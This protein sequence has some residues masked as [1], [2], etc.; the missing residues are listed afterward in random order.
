MLLNL[1]EFYKT[2]F[3]GCVMHKEHA[4]KL[5]GYVNQEFWSTC[6]KESFLIPEWMEQGLNLNI[7]A[8]ISGFEKEAKTQQNIKKYTPKHY[9]DFFQTIFK[10]HLY[11]AGINKMHNAQLIINNVELWNGVS[12][13][14]CH[15]HWDGP[16]NGD[17][18]A[19]VYLSDYKVWRV[20]FGG[21]LEV[22][23]AKAVAEQDGYNGVNSV[24]VYHPDNGRILLGDNR[25]PLYVHRANPL[26]EQA[27]K[28]INRFTFLVSMK[29]APLEHEE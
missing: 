29:L 21:G 13:G 24:A 1:S 17:I 27:P 3:T 5:R 4:L 26:T 19:L 7:S 25:N 18:Y 10:S 15:W 6:D 16:G 11:N 14:D 9:F 2:G 23:L 22:G 28:D 8:D 20:G 12:N